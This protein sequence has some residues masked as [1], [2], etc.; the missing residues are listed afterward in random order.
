MSKIQDAIRRAQFSAAVTEPS[1]P[2][3]VIQ[4]PSIAPSVEPDI[5]Y[6]PAPEWTYSG[7]KIEID[8]QALI[9]TGFLGPDESNERIISEYRP[10][11]HAVLQGVM[12]QGQLALPLGNLIMVSS[13]VAEE[14]KTFLCLNLAMSM[15]ADTRCSVVLVDSAVANPRLSEVLGAQTDT[16]LTD[17]IADSALK[18]EE[19]ISP[20]DIPG[21]AVL[22][23]G[24]QREKTSELLSD[25]HLHDRLVRIA[26]EDPQRIFL[27]DS[28]SVIK[29]RAAS[30][31]VENVGQVLFVVRAGETGRSLVRKALAELGWGRPVYVVLN[32]APAGDEPF[33]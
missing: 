22:P 32:Q 12:A 17:W 10:I 5:I 20:T 27:F 3:E 9:A 31:L 2:A 19:M 13:A 7:R 18:I 8:K 23:I 29:S 14:G 28:S 30:S 6:A 1:S 25:K 24:Q 33:M 16:G 21:L 4:A 26:A 15:A 11:K